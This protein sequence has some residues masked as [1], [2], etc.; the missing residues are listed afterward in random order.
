MAD[1]RAA[2]A[3]NGVRLRR[4][5]FVKG[6]GP[7]DRPAI[8]FLSLANEG[9][10]V[11]LR[12]VGV[13]GTMVQVLDPPFA[14]RVVDYKDILS[15]RQW[16]GRVLVPPI[17]PGMVRL[18]RLVTANRPRLRGRYPHCRQTF[19]TQSDRQGQR[20]KHTKRDEYRFK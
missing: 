11:V 20:R 12:P 1:L 17:V 4:A 6:D 3:Q 14:P 19:S 13:T 7:L 8:A 15:G 10:F 18:D 9:H 2:S 5:K 16:T